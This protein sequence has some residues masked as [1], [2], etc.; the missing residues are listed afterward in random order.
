MLLEV[1]TGKRPTDP[2]FGGELSIRQW[3]CGAFPAELSSVLDDLLLQDA[4][5]SD[6]D[7]NAFLP[8]IF[9]LG[10]IYSSDS[11]ERRMS[12]SDVLVTLQK[13]KKNYTESSAVAKD[14][15]ELH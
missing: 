3:V 4:S 8:S 1:F 10:L 13:I 5:S 2:M 9:E 12:M 7:L 11:P 15:E 6:C 14:Q